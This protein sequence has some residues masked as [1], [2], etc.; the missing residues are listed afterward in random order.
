MSGAAPST[1][2]GH[3]ESKSGKRKGKGQGSDVS[4]DTLNADPNASTTAIKSP[5]QPASTKGGSS[6]SGG[7]SGKSK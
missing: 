2:G 6:G 7:S 3:K 1:L 5:S 4:L